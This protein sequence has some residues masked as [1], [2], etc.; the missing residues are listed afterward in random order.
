MSV[1][2]FLPCRSGSTRVKDKN[3]KLFAGYKLG[4]FEIKVNQLVNARNISRVI[5][6]TDVGEALEFLDNFNNEKMKLTRGQ[7]NTVQITQPLMN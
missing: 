5:I 6:S 7:K 1:T 4:L 2:A 3:I